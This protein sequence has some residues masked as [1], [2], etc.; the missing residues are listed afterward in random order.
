MCISLY[1]AAQ[2]SL[3]RRSFPLRN[4]QDN[5]LFSTYTEFSQ[6]TP[7]ILLNSWTDSILLNFKS[8]LTIRDLLMA[9]VYS[10]VYLDKMN[11]DSYFRPDILIPPVWSTNWCI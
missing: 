10:V 7:R 9:Y 6:N 2:T 4:C 3:F 11:C 5:F 8:I 1:T